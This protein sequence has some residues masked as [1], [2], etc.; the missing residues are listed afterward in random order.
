M[1]KRSYVLLIVLTMVLSM[2][3]VNAQESNGFKDVTKDHWAKEAIELMTEEGIINGYDGYFRPDETVS[4]AEFAKML[5]KTLALEEKAPST[6]YFNDVFKS[7]WAYTY[8]ESA[9]NY[10][11]GFTSATGYRFKPDEASVRED[12]AV[13]VIK[14]LYDKGEV[15]DPNATDMT[16]LDAYSDGNDISSNLRKYVAAAVNEGLMVGSKGEF[17]P[18]GNLSRAEAA[19]LLGR[20]IDDEQKVVFEADNKVV[21]SDTSEPVISGNRTPT[22]EKVVRDNDVVLEWGQVASSGFKYYKVVLSKSDSTPSYSDNGYAKAISDVTST[23][24]ELK[25]G[26]GYN[27]GDVG[28]SIKDGET[29]YMAITAVY[30]DGKET[31]NVVSV[32]MPGTY[33]EVSAEKKTP[34]L[35]VDVRSGDVLLDWSET[36]SSGFKYYKVVLSSNDSSPSYSENGYAKA[37]GNVNDSFWEI[38]SGDGYNGGD[39]NGII[40]GGATYYVAITAVYEDGKYTSNVKQVTIPGNYTEVSSESRTPVLTYNMATSGVELNWSQVPSGGFSYYK[41]VLSQS[42]ENPYYPDYGY[43]TYIS[44]ASTTTYY[45]QEGAGYNDGSKGGIG[46][47]VED[48]NY[49]MTITAVYSSGKYTSN[50]VLVTVPDK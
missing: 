48:E 13:A 36:A 24:V 26:M 7:D 20:L 32:T 5:V 28:G 10:L 47:K 45:V 44:D 49:Y 17:D 6:P 33:V 37:I 12:M 31:S 21:I 29:Y 43:L 23:R 27:G 3:T 22:L 35:K 34:E 14:G 40:K 19:T 4:R 18:M 39:M 38:E 2:M 11:T 15:D 50:S 41:V 42:K 46:G 1:K 30:E 16:V 8:V 9:R 25:S